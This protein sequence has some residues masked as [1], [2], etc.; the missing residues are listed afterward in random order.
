MSAFSAAETAGHIANRTLTDRPLRLRT[1]PCACGGE[2]TADVVDP[3]PEVRRHNETYAHRLWWL[4][5]EADWQG[6]E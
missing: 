5:Q 1:R 6:D 3:G 4:R 2:I